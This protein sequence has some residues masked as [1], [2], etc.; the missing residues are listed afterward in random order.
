MEE[1]IEL[2]QY[3]KRYIESGF[4]KDFRQFGQWLV[5]Q[6]NEQK[7]ASDEWNSRVDINQEGLDAV[8]GFQ[9][10]GLM[11]Y[12]D[13]WTKLAFRNLPLVG[14]ADFGILKFIEYTGSP[15]KKSISLTA[16]ME[17]STCFEILKRLQKNNLIEEKPDSEDKRVKRVKLTAAGKKVIEQATIQVKALSGFLVGNLSEQEKLQLLNAL[18]KLNEFHHHWY[19]EGD[20]EKLMEV[21]QL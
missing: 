21:Y 7:N 11:S 10:G 17:A 20:K 1:V 5:Q 18:K 15:T 6:N 12:S 4:N 16:I 8:L 9:L 3:W 14:I 19:H 13:T 2:L